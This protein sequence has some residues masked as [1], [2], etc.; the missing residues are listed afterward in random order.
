MSTQITNP[1]NNA[2]A[3][4]NDDLKAPP[5]VQSMSDKYNEGKQARNFFEQQ[6]R[7]QCRTLKFGIP[8]CLDC[9]WS[10]KDDDKEAEWERF[11]ITGKTR[12]WYEQ[13]R[14]LQFSSFTCFFGGCICSADPIDNNN[15]KQYK[16]NDDLGGGL[17]A[18]IVGGA[19]GAAVNEYVDLPQ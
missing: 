19:I 16:K 15:N 6:K 14:R 18:G 11:Q 17:A 13:M 3:P 2:S 12:G 9:V 1:M 4:P 7:M 5:T 8:N 10:E